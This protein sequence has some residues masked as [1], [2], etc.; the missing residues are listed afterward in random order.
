M[1]NKSS[2]IFFTLPL[3]ESRRAMAWRSVASSISG[4]GNDASDECQGD[5]K[6]AISIETQYWVE[7]ARTLKAT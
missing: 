3:M 6:L 2:R 5:D 7:K 1:R 4:S